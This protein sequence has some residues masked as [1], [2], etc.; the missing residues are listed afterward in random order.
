LINLSQM[1]LS[2][3]LPLV[4]FVGFTV[5]FRLIIR[6]FFGRRKGAVQ[7]DRCKCG[8][9]LE[10]L[11]LARCPECGRVISFDA[12]AEDLGLTDEQLHRAQTA[13]LRR[14]SE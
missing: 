14:K 2:M 1:I 4:A 12:T 6:R 9:S 10:N 3:L 13:R 8:Y 7:I 11:S 5:G